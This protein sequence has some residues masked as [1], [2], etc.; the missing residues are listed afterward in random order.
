MKKQNT[1]QPRII[2]GKREVRNDS[3]PEPKYKIPMPAEPS[4]SAPTQKAEPPPKSEKK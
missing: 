2:P 1:N 4:K 3:A